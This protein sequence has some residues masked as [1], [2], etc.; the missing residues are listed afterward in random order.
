MFS[1]CLLYWSNRS[2]AQVCQNIAQLCGTF[3]NKASTGHYSTCVQLLSISMGGVT[4]VSGL[5]IATNA[6]CHAHI[7]RGNVDKI[8]ALGPR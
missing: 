1:R 2:K 4:L 8:V 3:S 5:A 7:H 6:I